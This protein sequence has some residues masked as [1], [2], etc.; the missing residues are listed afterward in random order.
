MI[1]NT[2][3]E[4]TQKA[5]L[6][7][8]THALL[9]YA[10]SKVLTEKE[11]FEGGLA[12]REWI[13][14]QANW[15]GEEMKKAHTALGMPTDVEH[16]QRFWDNALSDFWYRKEGKYTTY[17]VS[18]QVPACAYADVW[19]ERDWW[20][21]GHVYCDELH[22]HILETYN[23]DGAVVIPKCLMKG[24]SQCDF[25]WILTPDAKRNPEEVKPD[26]PGQDHKKD[27]LAETPEE[28]QYKN[29]RRGTR[30]LGMELFMLEDVL[31]R[32]FPER[33]E[34][35]YREITELFAEERGK[36]FVKFYRTYKEGIFSFIRQNFDM[37]F[38]A[39]SP[40][41]MEEKPILR[42]K[43]TENPLKEGFAYFG[44]EQEADRFM[45]QQ[46][47]Q[48]SGTEGMPVKLWFEKMSDGERELVFEIR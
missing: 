17:D 32:R 8:R 3:D 30:L 16:I 37:P 15:R 40:I 25:R 4:L 2:F 39:F 31:E 45:E 46:C 38:A 10:V 41:F 13:R 27:Y 12:V 5:G 24:D 23:P 28:A 42:V 9:Y 7:M 11:G 18:M 21:W 6:L 26:Y 19:Q 43:F 33:K 22:Q 1:R 47:R 36:D 34:T 20:M 29:I 48:M 44:M 35:R 14:V